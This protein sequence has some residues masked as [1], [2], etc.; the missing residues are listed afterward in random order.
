[1]ETG[2][3]NDF[4]TGIH[5]FLFDVHHLRDNAENNPPT[6]LVVPMGKASIGLPHIRVV[7]WWAATS[8]RNCHIAVPD[9]MT[10]MQL[11]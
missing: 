11:N 2:Q 6:S 3:T 1:M 5:S 4:K 8:K 7:D 10:N 9:N